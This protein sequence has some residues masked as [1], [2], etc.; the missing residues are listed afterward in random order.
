MRET[1]SLTLSICGELDQHRAGDIIGEIREKIDLYLPRILILD[2][3][4]LVFCDSSGIALLLR[5]K[6]SMK[7]IEGK[8]EVINIQT[9][10]KRLF[11]LAG[12]G[13]L[14]QDRHKESQ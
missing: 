13:E 10:P 5:V 1:P 8:L 11:Q 9:Q 12:L 14:I 4:E 6:R 2:L 3:E 7:Q